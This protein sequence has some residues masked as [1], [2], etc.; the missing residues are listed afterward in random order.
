VAYLYAGK[1][2]YSVLLAET[3]DNVQNV[4]RDCYRIQLS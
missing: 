2:F 4:S 3:M 1:R